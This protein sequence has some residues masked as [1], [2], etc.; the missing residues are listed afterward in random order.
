M[1]RRLP[2]FLCAVAF[3]GCSQAQTGAPDA[4]AK[5]PVMT[6]TF[7]HTPTPPQDRLVGIAYSTWHQ[8]KNWGTNSWGTPATGAYASDDKAVIQQHARQLQAAGVDFVLEDWSNN[9]G[10]V[11]DPAKKRPDFDMIEGATFTLFDEWT[12]LRAAGE[13]TPNISIMAG[14]TGAPAAADDGRLQ[15]KA[16]QIWNQF[17]ANPV[18]RPLVQMDGGKPLLVIYVN[19][20]SPFQN[21]VPKWNDSRF[22]VR[23]M[24]GYVTEQSAL[25]TPDLISKYGYWSWE[26]RGPQTFPVVDGQPESMVI[27]AA[28][29]P[30][31]KP[32]DR[33]YIPAAPRSNGETFK[34]AWARAREIGPKY[35][36][37]V[38]WNE[39]HKG[40][41][42]TPEI[43]K[44]IEPSKEFGNL[45]LDLLKQEIADFK[46]GR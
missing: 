2:L 32:G 10:Y 20:P 1:M 7:Q 22:V 3:V 11:Y 43:S 40:E 30:Q 33:Y 35:A 21:G 37:V 12:K 24:T 13:K 16:D 27:T 46:A 4:P 17:V 41:Q 25:R 8:N 34:R 28:V 36:L 19:T 44:D 42:P 23:W 6:D 39:W 29:R 45:Y 14:V 9:I 31:G 38:S 18:Y 26:D 15:R 5:A